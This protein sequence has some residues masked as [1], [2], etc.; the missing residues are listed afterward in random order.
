MRVYRILVFLLVL[1]FYRDALPFEGAVEKFFS[2]NPDQK[3][4]YTTM[5]IVSID[6]IEFSSYEKYLIQMSLVSDIEQEF[7]RCEGINR[8]VEKYTRDAE[9]MYLGRKS[10][11]KNIKDNSN[12]QS[13][14][15]LYVF[16]NSIC[17]ENGL[18]IINSDGSIQWKNVYTTTCN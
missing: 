2:T 1:L 18:I 13:D 17:E 4:Y 7:S 10:L 6:Y 11:L 14:L 15:Y 8:L 12:P 9:H 5:A 3:K 16:E